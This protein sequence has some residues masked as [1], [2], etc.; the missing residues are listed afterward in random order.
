MPHLL[1]QR[2]LGT[3]GNRPGGARISSRNQIAIDVSHLHKTY[4]YGRRR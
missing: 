4:G 1:C 3:I 2:E